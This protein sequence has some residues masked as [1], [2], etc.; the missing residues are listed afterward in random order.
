MSWPALADRDQVLA[1]LRDEA[2]PGFSERLG[3]LG[4]RTDRAL[5]VPMPRL[6]LLARR[7]GKSQGLADS[8]WESGIHEA[9]TVAVLIAEPG[10]MT[11]AVARRWIHAVD[12]WDLCDRLCVDLLKDTPFSWQLVQQWSRDAGEF[13]RRGAAVIVAAHAIH[14]AARDSRFRW[15]LDQLEP[16]SG[17]PRLFVRKGLTWAAR[18]VGK[19]NAALR[20]EVLE[21]AERWACSDNELQ[22][23]LGRRLSRELVQ[24]RP[25]QRPLSLPSRR[26]RAS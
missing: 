4:I 21:R 11:P 24:E 8:L 14:S 16:I 10:T 26:R 5:G 1:R 7:L 23:T 19:R 2:V 15:A 13:V 3:A 22:R 9:R 20:E 25:S 18:Q 12:S 17:D 6:R